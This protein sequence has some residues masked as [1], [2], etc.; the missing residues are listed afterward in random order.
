MRSKIKRERLISSAIF[1]A[2]LIAVIILIE[3]SDKIPHSI[4][5]WSSSLFLLGS[6]FFSP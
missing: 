4:A 5:V 1:S 2:Y 6:M 3:N